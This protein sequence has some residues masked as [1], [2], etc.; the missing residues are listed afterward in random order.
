[1][2][3]CESTIDSVTQDMATWSHLLIYSYEWSFLIPYILFDKCSE[4]WPF[5]LTR[6]NSGAAYGG[7]PQKVFSFWPSANLLQKPKSQILMRS[8]LT[9]KTFSAF[10]SRC[11]TNRLWQYCSAVRIC[12]KSWRAV[13]SFN[14]PD[15]SSLFD[16][17]PSRREEF[18]PKQSIRNSTIV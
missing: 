13:C 8:S 15:F 11:T 2:S 4:K 17:E 5:E 9:N 18:Q 6:N 14:C 16:R 1:M 3:A 12:L 10:R 7:L